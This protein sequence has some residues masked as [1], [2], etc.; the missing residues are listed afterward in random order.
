MIKSAKI[1]KN[2]NKF[3]NYSCQYVEDNKIKVCSFKT[4]EDAITTAFLNW[5]LTKETQLQNSTI[6][7]KE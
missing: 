4:Y 5:N 7:E 2:P 6:L 1:N 3:G